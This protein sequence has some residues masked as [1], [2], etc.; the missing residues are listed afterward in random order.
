MARRK[1]QASL[2]DDIFDLL[3]ITPIWVGPLLA[4]LTFALFRYIAPLAFPPR[5]DAPDV[6]VVLRDFLPMLGWILAGAV[7]VLWIAAELSKLFSRKL[8]DRQSGIES[9]RELSWPA[10]E[11]LVCEGYRRKGFVAQTVGSSSGDGGVDVEL[12][13]GGRRVLVQCKQWRAFKV[14]VATIREMLG[15]VVSQRASGGIVVTSGR[16]TQEARRFAESNPLIELV[17]GPEL[18]RLIGG[19]QL[20]GKQTSLRPTSP[21][22]PLRAASP[23]CPLCGSIMVSRKAR[24]GHL[25]GT[26]FWGCSKFPACRGTRAV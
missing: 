26:Q 9:I 8:L 16:F 25:E 17:D 10:F 7:L 23:S 2:F 20:S 15:V 13:S 14:G 11:Q 4:V 5:H 12:H 21:T 19:V 6:G 22:T 1:N 18:A 3:T 24:R